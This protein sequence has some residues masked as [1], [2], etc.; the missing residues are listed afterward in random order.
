[1]TPTPDRRADLLDRMADFV[2][3][4]GLAAAS[5]RPLAQAAGISD[6]MLL[7]YFKDKS[8]VITAILT[9]VSQRLKAALD[10]RTTTPP[11]PLGRLRGRVVRLVLDE[12]FWP[13]MCLRVEIAAQAARGDALCRKVGEDL[14]RIVLDWIT[15]QLDSTDQ[16]EALRLLMQVDGT[17]LLK[18]AGLFD[19]ARSK[20]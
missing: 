19:P 1:M 11:L 2:L 14:G 3:S 7:Y 9:L 6:R 10:T 8:E 5:L 20:A 17:V 13:Y 4:Q 18:M 15:P 12:A 16:A